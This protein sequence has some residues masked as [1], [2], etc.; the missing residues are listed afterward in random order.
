M[1]RIAARPAWTFWFLAG[2]GLIAGAAV[3]P[4]QLP[5][6]PAPPGKYRVILRYDIPAPRDPHVV[7]YDAMI[8]HLQSL[9][10]EFDPPLAKRPDT[11]R[12]DRSKNRMEGFIAPDK[13]LRILEDPSVASMILIP[14]D[15]KLPDQ[16]DQPVLVR[17]EL[18]GGL[19][20]ERQRELSD[21]V[22]GLLGFH[23]FREAV[24]YDHRGRSGQPF[25]RL[26]GTV[27]AGRLETLLKDL[28]GQPGG[29][30]APVM[31]PTELPLPLRSINPVRVIEVLREAEP[32]KTVSPPEPRNP[33]YLE[34]ISPE[35]WEL[36]NQP[37]PPAKR[38]RVQV[39]FTEPLPD[40]DAA[41]RQGLAEVVPDFFIEG[42]LGQFVTGTLPPAQIKTLAALPRVSVVRLPRLTRDDVDPAL[43]FPRD[44]ARVLA[45]SGVAALHQ[46]GAKGKGVRLGIIDTD[47]RGWQELVK[48]G[49]LP[50][51]TRLVDLTAERDPNLVPAP[52]PGEPDQLGH[53]TVC[54]QAAALA[55]PLAD[56][57]LIRTDAIAP[58]QLR[59]IGRYVQQGGPYSPTIEV[60]R[61]ELVIARAALTRRRDEL[62][63]D[64][65]RILQNFTDEAELRERL[66]FLG[67]VYGWLY[68]ERTW[69]F[70]QMKQQDRLE[71]ELKKREARMDRFLG[72]ID[73]LRGLPILT[74][75]LV[76]SDGFPL[77]GLSPLSRWLDQDPAG[78]PLWFQS[79]GNK[80]GQCWM[81]DF[82]S[83]A[84]SP[85][86]DF[87]PPAAKPAKDQ[88]TGEL[89]FLAWQPYQ[90][91]RT[92]E[93]P[94]KAQIRLTVQWREPH[95]PDY[96]LRP[97]EP[98]YYRKPLASL[99][100]QLLRQRDPEAKSA[101]ADL[102]D[103]VAQSAGWPQRLEHLPGGSVYEIVLD[104]T[105][106][107]PGRYAV[108][109]EKQPDTQWVVGL[110]PIRK[111]PALAKLE[112]LNP[113]GIRPL[114]VPALPAQAPDWELRLR[115]F[116]E[117]VDDTVRLVGRTVFADYWTDAG[118]VGMPVDSR[119]V[120][121][122]GA[123]DLDG[124]PQPYSATGAPAFVELA[125]RPT[126]LAYDALQLDGGAAFGTDVANAY[127]A[128]TAAT[129]LS[130][131][132]P[133]EPLRTWL[134]AQGGKVLRVPT[135]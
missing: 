6:Q 41:W 126:L 8:R 71:E 119:G 121:S 95:D 133:R 85:V 79:A 2:A 10:F 47:F 66:G 22:R 76:W 56:L 18:A 130:A 55:A 61:D 23:Q 125:C 75:S 59:E 116:V 109:L 122:V 14:D 113:V 58:Y 39:I 100:L 102:F 108:R 115:L 128:G 96:Y 81:G 131:G 88:W 87:A 90:G 49:K 78:K 72:G 60:R 62:L 99:K 7:Q 16:P 3:L 135:K 19:L 77:G 101:P 54:A 105:I 114:G 53:G 86:L 27:P 15:V 1:S 98:D 89:N 57:V 33:E 84:G 46:R 43:K 80:R 123:A 132:T 106:D 31:P 120:V 91:E 24:G 45:Q 104:V 29:W 51:R 52:Y 13:A 30:L 127:A 74:N 28:R 26:V 25:T 110:H 83:A 50:A 70:E 73:S 129:L 92:A 69:H 5:R 103:V 32:L 40:A 117:T 82:R 17:L 63:K 118:T 68:S 48:A 42:H 107:K 134:L 94:E 12:E 65:Q 21:Q 37:E 93:L 4:A 44:N 64:R 111:L 38:V 97:G 9:G 67:A 11:D 36:V 124:R 112:G 35:L 34:K 20:P